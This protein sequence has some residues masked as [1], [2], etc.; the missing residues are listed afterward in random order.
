MRNYWG[1]DPRR[2]HEMRQSTTRWHQPSD[3]FNRRAI[4]SRAALLRVPGVR[5][6]WW[7]PQNDCSDKPEDSGN[8]G[9][10]GRSRKR[11]SRTATIAAGV[12]PDLRV[13]FD[14]S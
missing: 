2:D 4:V 1:P 12:S 3:L 11:G 10:H 14:Y 5:A 8:R 6:S 13:T 9:V 7:R